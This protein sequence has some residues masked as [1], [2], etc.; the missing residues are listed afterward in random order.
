MGRAWTVPSKDPKDVKDIKDRKDKA[1]LGF[2][3]LGV[4]YVF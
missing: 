3:V 2:F 4:L 1:E